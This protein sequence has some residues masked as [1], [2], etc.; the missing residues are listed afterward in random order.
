MKSLE[1]EENLLKP[2]FPYDGPLQPQCCLNSFLPLL[3]SAGALSR[4][5][6]HLFQRSEDCVLTL[7]AIQATAEPTKLCPRGL[8]RE[9]ELQGAK[10][11]QSFLTHGGS[12]QHCQCG[13][14]S[15][16]QGPRDHAT[17]MPP[18]LFLCFQHPWV[19]ACLCSQKW[20]GAF[21]PELIDNI[22]THIFWQTLYMYDRENQALFWSGLRVEAN[23][24]SFWLDSKSHCFY[25]WKIR[26]YVTFNIISFP[27]LFTVV[28]GFLFWFFA[29]IKASSF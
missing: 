4:G 27:F 9:E 19:W 14:T 8:G 26:C 24:L 18:P 13:E 5:F 15:V 17:E 22:N 3:A 2:R 23:S 1:K 21:G 7:K 12:M 20:K 28:V 11:A 6:S 25:R 29:F 10:S 16:G